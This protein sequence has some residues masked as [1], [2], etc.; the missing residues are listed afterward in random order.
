MSPAV[1][2]LGFCL[3]AAGERYRICDKVWHA[4]SLLQLL[5]RANKESNRRVLLLHTGAAAAAAGGAAGAAATAAAAATATKIPIEKFQVQ[6]IAAYV[7]PAK[8]VAAFGDFISRQSYLQASNKNNI[9]QNSK[10]LILYPSV[11]TPKHKQR[12][13]TKNKQTDRQTT[14]CFAS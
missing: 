4:V 12:Q 14:S 1:C 3:S 9:R 7:D 10:S 6:Q 11:H 5:F 2:F 8:E 13:K